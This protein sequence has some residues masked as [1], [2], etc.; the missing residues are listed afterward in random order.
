MSVLKFTSAPARFSW[1]S[2][3]FGL[4]AAVHASCLA[5][6]LRHRVKEAGEFLNDGNGA[7]ICV[8]IAPVQGTIM[9]WRRSGEGRILRSKWQYLLAAGLLAVCLMIGGLFAAR[10]LRSCVVHGK[11]YYSGE[12]VPCS[13]CNECWCL[14]GSTGE[15]AKACARP[16]DVTVSPPK[17]AGDVA[18]RNV[19]NSPLTG[20]V[21]P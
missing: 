11:R 19:G 14:N 2:L 8:M 17:G 10:F 6:D 1:G 9:I 7:G 13:P 18:P 12:A 5:T 15:T 4:S 3:L 16:P 21:Y 20:K